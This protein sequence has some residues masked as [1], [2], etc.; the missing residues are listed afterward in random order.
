MQR[1]VAISFALLI[2]SATLAAQ[3]VDQYRPQK[4]D[5]QA[6]QYQPK[7]MLDLSRVADCPV[8]MRAQQGGGGNM[9]KVQPGQPR[10]SHTFQSIHLILGNGNPR[11]IVVARVKVRGLTDKGRLQPASGQEGPSEI[12]RIVDV[13]FSGDETSGAAA[14][15]VLHGLTS[16]RWIDLESLTY[17]DG[18]TWNA[19]DLTC[20][21]VPDPWMLV[22]VR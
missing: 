19:G 2:G 7:L 13:T 1:V 14:D 4:F 22:D 21:T 9:V 11:R 17:A 3:A 18:S 12:T 5:P 15:L 8:A 16:V 20:R 10:E 6:A